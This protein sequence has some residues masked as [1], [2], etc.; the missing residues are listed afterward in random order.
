MTTHKRRL[1]NKKVSTDERGVVPRKPNTAAPSKQRNGR[2]RRLAFTPS[3]YVPGSVLG[4]GD[5]AMVQTRIAL[6]KTLQ[7]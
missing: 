2:V 7:T 1:N 3:A 4:S 5:T 6:S